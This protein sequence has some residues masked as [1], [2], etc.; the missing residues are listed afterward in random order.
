MHRQHFK[1][2][3]KDLVNSLAGKN[4]PD[5]CGVSICQ[6]RLFYV[7]RC[8]VSRELSPEKASSQLLNTEVVFGRDENEQCYS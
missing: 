6:V 3:G 5:F 2:N 1:T 8:S 4:D 7:W